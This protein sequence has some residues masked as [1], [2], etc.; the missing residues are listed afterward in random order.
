MI[1]NQ[2]DIG[3]AVVFWSLAEWTSRDKLLQGFNP[4]GLNHVVPEMRA[5]PAALRDA[6][7]EVL[8]GPRVLVR[9]LS[10][11]DG[12]TVVREERGPEGNSYAQELVACMDEANGSTDIRFHP[13]D[14]RAGRVQE[15]YQR[16]RGRLHGSQVSNVL[17]YLI[18]S[19]GGTRLRPS[20]ALYWLP[21]NR[22]DNW[23]LVAQAVEQS[24]EGRPSAVYLLRHRMDADA[25]R[26]VTDA[27]VSEINVEAG[28]I[29]DEVMAGELGERALENRRE[30]AA[31]LRQKVVLYEELLDVGLS[32]LHQAVDRADQA[33]AAAALLVSAQNNPAL[34]AQAG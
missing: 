7:E 25:V 5:A 10:R 33:A 29:H 1:E 3:G 31:S 12:F 14:D 17:V 19:L 20:G 24:G 32:G 16:Q 26:A 13:Q 6:L 9:P 34:V 11:R 15:A 21:G 4:L 28:R 23:Q 2:L 27:I 22:I 8:G 18:E 30:L